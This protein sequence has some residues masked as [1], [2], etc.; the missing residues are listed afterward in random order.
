MT[1]DFFIPI[2]HSTFQFSFPLVFCPFGLNRWR[3]TVAAC[4]P[5][6]QLKEKSEGC[7]VRAA[8]RIADNTPIQLSASRD[9]E[10]QTRARYRAGLATVVEVAEA[11][12]LLVQ[13]SIEDA[14]A[15]LGVW[16]ALLGLAGARGNLQPFFEQFRT[17]TQG[18]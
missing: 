4:K 17:S 1:S 9:T 18:S 8:R 3:R 7:T 15:R 12:H 10:M 5:S 2:Q 14:L 16:R 6:E 13:A 11:Q